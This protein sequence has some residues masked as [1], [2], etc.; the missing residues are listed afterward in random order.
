[1]TVRLPDKPPGFF[2]FRRQPGASRPGQIAAGQVTAPRSAAILRGAMTDLIITNGDSAAELLLPAGRE[3][4]V[5]PWRDVLHEGPISRGSLAECTAGA[6]RLSRRAISGSI[7][8]KSPRISPSA[9][10][11]SRA[12][13]DFERVEL[14]FEHDLYDQLQ[15]IQVLAFFA[16]EEPRDGLILVQA[17]DFLGSQT[18]ETI[19]GFADRARA[20]FVGRSR[21]R[22]Q[23]LGRSRRADTGARSPPGWTGR[24]TSLPFLRPALCA[25]SRSC[26]RRVRASAAPSTTLLAAIAD[27]APRPAHLFRQ[28]IAAEQAAFMGDWSFF[29]LLD[30]L[31]VCAMPLIAGLACRSDGVRRRTLPRRRPG[32]DR[33]RRGRAGRRGGSRRLN[34]LDRWWA[35]TRLIGRIRLALRSR[36]RTTCAAAGFSAA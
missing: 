35:G 6:D 21:P 19:L 14:W 27:G 23:R 34:G 3:A 10:A 8:P 29:R 31:A 36:R 26:R 18:A 15:L 11:S 32:A 28:V 13:R 5:L 30:D 20:G 33:G 9:T 16:G 7:P 4:T 17:D 2:S 25:S 24:P 1:M 22:G 12:H